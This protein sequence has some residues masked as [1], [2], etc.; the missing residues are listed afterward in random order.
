MPKYCLAGLSSVCYEVPFRR[1]I[2]IAYLPNFKC[3]FYSTTSSNFIDYWVFLNALLILTPFITSVRLVNWRYK[4]QLTTF[5]K[6]QMHIR[7]WFYWYMGNEESHKSWLAIVMKQIMNQL[8]VQVTIRGTISLTI[9]FNIF[10]RFLVI[11][12]DLERGNNFFCY[13]EKGQA[14]QVHL[15]AENQSPNLRPQQWTWYQMISCLT[16]EMF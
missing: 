4:L 3:R 6:R 9:I 10:N 8:I 14:F 7:C 16:V 2:T 5:L 13:K 15:S 12:N 1:F 11:H